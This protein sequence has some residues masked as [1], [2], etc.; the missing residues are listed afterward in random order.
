DEL[1]G[2]GSTSTDRAQATLRSAWTLFPSLSLN[3]GIWA[4]YDDQTFADRKGASLRAEPWLSLLF[5]AGGFDVE[6]TGK[7]LAGFVS[8]DDARQIE[9]VR[10]QAAI[11]ASGPFAGGLGWLIA[12]QLNSHLPQPWNIPS[13]VE[14]A[15]S[16]ETSWGASAGPVWRSDRSELKASVFY[17]RVSDYWARPVVAISRDTGRFDVFGVE[18]DARWRPLKTLDLR[19]GLAWAEDILEDTNLEPVR[20]AGALLRGL[21]SIRYAFAQR[22]F[23]EIHARWITDALPLGDQPRLNIEAGAPVR[24]GLIGGVE[25]GHGLSLSVAVENVLDVAYDDPVIDRDQ[26]GLDA[27]LALTFSGG[28]P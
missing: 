11:V 4:Q 12:L 21:A 5:S 26:V 24:V 9:G 13:I 7:V 10:P 6:L 15:S 25:L 19:I 22:G 16:F 18:V 3:T 27:R 2:V 1:Q 28:R 17:Q 20:P 8:V 14:R 23:V